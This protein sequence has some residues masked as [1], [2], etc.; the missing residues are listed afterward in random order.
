MYSDEANVLTSTRKLSLPREVLRPKAS[1]HLMDLH[2][3]PF[4]RADAANEEPRVVDLCGKNA[5]G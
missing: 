3:M 2:C 1:I 5:A 4:A